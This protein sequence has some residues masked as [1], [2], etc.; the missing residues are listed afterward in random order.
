MAD[1]TALVTGGAGGLGRSVVD[2]LLGAG[3]RVVVPVEKAGDLG[4]RAGLSTVTA[5]LTDPDDV[6]RA[7]RA[8][9]AEDGAPLRAVV[10]LVGGFAAGQPV[11]DTPLEDFERLF[12]LN[13]RPTYLVTQAALP[14]LAAAGGGAIVC[15]GSSA[16]LNP[17]AGGA[18]YA[19]SKAAVIAFARAV[20]AEGKPDGVRCNAIV[21]T[22]ID[23]PAN[24]AAM[25]ESEHHKLVPPERIAQVVAFL[26]ADAS[27]AISGAAVP[28]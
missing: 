2:A 28:V 20:A 9:V 6:A 26:C 1:R 25:P 7:I 3:W 27:A 22:Q 17:F 5:D 14:R 8:A 12:A 10:N 13:L 16:A 15:V 21:P 19:A 11:A 23:T 24:R 4:E 18:G